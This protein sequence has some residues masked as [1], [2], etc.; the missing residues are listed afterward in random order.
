[1]QSN[2]IMNMNWPILVT[3]TFD[4]E[5]LMRSTLDAGWNPHVQGTPIY[6]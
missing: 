3:E 6:D 2:Y 1:M 5:T 4:F